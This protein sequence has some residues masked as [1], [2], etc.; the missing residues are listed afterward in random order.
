[1]LPTARTVARADARRKTGAHA[2]SVLRPASLPDAG[3][4]RRVLGA[5]ARLDDARLGLLAETV[6][7][8]ARDLFTMLIRFFIHAEA[9]LFGEA[10]AQ[11]IQPLE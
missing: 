9:F 7:Q 5:Q 1:M 10:I 4:R 6:Q 11:A 8:E 2:S 3:R